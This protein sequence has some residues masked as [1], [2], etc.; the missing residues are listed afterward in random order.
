MLN[1]MSVAHQ[2]C[3]VTEGFGPGLKVDREAGVI[4]GVKL[5]GR[6]SRNGREYPESTIV[7]ARSLYEG[8]KVNVNH[9]SKPG[10]PS[11]YEQRIGYVDAIQVRPDGLFGNF[12]FNPKHALAEQLLWDAEHAPQSVGFSHDVH[13]VTSNKTGRV[14]VEQITKV[15][16]VDL[17]ADP[18][19]T[20]GLHEQIELESNV[21]IT[22]EAVKAKPEIV[23]AILQEHAN[24]EAVKLQEQELKT[25]KAKLDGYESLHRLEQKKAAVAKAIK[26]AKLPEALV[27]ETFVELCE[28]A[29]DAGLAKLIDDRLVVAK[30]I[31]AGSKPQS[32]EQ[33]TTEQEVSTADIRAAL[34]G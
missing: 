6:T 26:E 16:S 33:R 18:A 31:P 5:L 10:E 15:N 13:A 3:D 11:T 12:H 32:K 2:F 14:V 17:V 19:T 27:T 7:N 28:G 20:S 24:S 25:L 4:A 34:A 1:G 8:A 22:L 23:K 30:G 9:K 21:E 29:D